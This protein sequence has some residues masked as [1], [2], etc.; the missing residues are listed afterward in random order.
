MENKLTFE[1]AIAQL[2]TIV[3]ELESGQLSLQDAVQ[4]YEEGMRLA[5]QCTT[6]LER[7]EDVVVKLMSQGKLQDFDL[8]AEEE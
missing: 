2:E 3:K 8:P 4:K 7:A 1:E 6:E 5:K